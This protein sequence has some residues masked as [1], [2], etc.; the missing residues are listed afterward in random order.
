MLKRGLQGK[1]ILMDAA[2]LDCADNP[3]AAAAFDC[4]VVIFGILGDQIAMIRPFHFGAEAKCARSR[5]RPYKMAVDGPK[6]PPD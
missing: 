3:F 5:R 6:S 1:C 2:V 4:D